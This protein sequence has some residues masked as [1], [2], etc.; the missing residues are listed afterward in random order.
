MWLGREAVRG[1]RRGTQ[2]G[3]PRASMKL[4]QT[5]FEVVAQS[6]PFIET[7]LTAQRGKDKPRKGG[8]PAGPWSC[9]AADITGWVRQGTLCPPH[10]CQEPSR[11]PCHGRL[12]KGRRGHSV[13]KIGSALLGRGSCLGMLPGVSA[14]A[15]GGHPRCR[16]SF[17]C[18]PAR[19]ARA[20][21]GTCTC[22]NYLC[23]LV[24]SRHAVSSDNSLEPGF[25]HFC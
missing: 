15:A 25:S 20:S 9:R 6:L 2:R 16:L 23:S 10:H 8:C 18:A 11:A 7:A 1:T 5:R 19:C 12:R 14:W 13:L 21:P 24:L 17:V 22:R 4:R 3:W